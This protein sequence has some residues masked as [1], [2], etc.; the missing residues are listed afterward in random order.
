MSAKTQEAI[1]EAI[2]TSRG[3][4]LQVAVEMEKMMEIYISER[5]SSEDEKI[6]EL[7]MLI[8]APRM[9]LSQKK[10]VFDFLLEKYHPEFRNANIETLNKIQG[11]IFQ[12]NVFAHWPVEFSQSAMNTYDTK[13]AITLVKLKNFR[14]E[15]TKQLQL[16]E[17]FEYNQDKTNEWLNTFIEVNK[18][19]NQ[20]IFDTAPLV[21]P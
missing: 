4:I 12:R 10:E 17:K 8:I 3:K 6:Q 1:L 13:T 14:D 11:L 2:R 9:T 20:L 21:R 7:I 16:G 15:K 19:L 5:F 18:V